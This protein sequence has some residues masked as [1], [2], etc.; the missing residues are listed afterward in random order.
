MLFFFCIDIAHFPQATECCIIIMHCF[1]AYSQIM[2]SAGERYIS[3]RYM[4]STY[5]ISL[6]IYNSKKHTRCAP[7]IVIKGD[8]LTLFINGLNWVSL[9]WNFTLLIGAFA[10]G[11]DLSTRRSPIPWDKP[12]NVLRAPT[13]PPPAV[14]DATVSFWTVFFGGRGKGAASDDDI[15]STNIGWI[16]EISETKFI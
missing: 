1:I 6:R 15:Y 11:A 14:K 2:E 16:G 4:F 5:L 7:T 13:A 10:S 9:G 3:D 12:S 8:V